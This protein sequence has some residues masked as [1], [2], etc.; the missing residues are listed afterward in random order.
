MKS[1]LFLVCALVILVG[2]MLLTAP[3]AGA[4]DTSKR[5]V[6][7]FEKEAVPKN[8]A[9]LIKAAG[10]MLV[11]TFPQVG[12]A[13]ATS[14]RRDFATALEGNLS[15]SAVGLERC[16][17]LPDD[18]VFA[19]P[20]G[21]VWPD[22]YFYF[23]NQWNIRRVKADQA[24]PINS[25]SHNT[26]VAV[27]DTGIASNH[28]DL[29]PNLVYSAC[30]SVFNPCDP[31]PAY[32]YHGTHVAG[33][34]AAAF[35]GGAC[36]GVGPNLGLASYNVFERNNGSITAYDESIWAAMLDAAE[37]GF[38]V[39]TMSLGGYGVFPEGDAALWTAYNRVANYVVRQGVV[40]VASAGNLDTDL[41]GP[42][43][44]IPSDVPAIICVGATGIRPDPEFPQEDFFDVRA[45]Y[46]NYGTPVDMVAPGGDN[47]PIGTNYDY[48]VL[49][50]YV[51]AAP[52]CAA[53][54]SCDYAYAWALG[55]SMATPH[56]AGVAGL[57]LDHDPGL[58]PRQVKAILKQTAESLGD[59]QEFGHGMVDALAALNK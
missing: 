13:I 15:V 31:Y 23:Y 4:A 48:W 44:H 50:D 6:V 47:G 11:K 20:T 57:L 58:T 27:I 54:A 17:S 52:D 16:Q 46:S 53:T 37:Q 21:P 26:V 51:F 41:N 28:P 8:A 1:K 19:E 25:G 3:L 30:Y 7:V 5:Y 42:Q 45:Y 39:I 32:S 34:V 33:I 43:F 36:V 35:G 12:L 2:G 38:A 24:W 10:G 59:R 56:V 18:K 29:A 22:D 14:T 9:S 49:S 40:I 55:T